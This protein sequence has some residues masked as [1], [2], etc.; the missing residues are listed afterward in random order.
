MLLGGATALPSLPCALRGL[1]SPPASTDESGCNGSSWSLRALREEEEEITEMNHLRVPWEMGAAASE[2]RS[3]AGGAGDGGVM[4]EASVPPWTAP[5]CP[6]TAVGSSQVT[7]LAQPPVPAQCLAG[8]MGCPRASA[9]L[10]LQGG[11][12]GRSSVRHIRSPPGPSPGW[13]EP[14]PSATAPALGSTVPMALAQAW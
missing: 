6:A 2:G 10:E 8:A 13:Q 11:A 7:A 14:A 5:P 9:L 3:R 1:R 4:S 12:K